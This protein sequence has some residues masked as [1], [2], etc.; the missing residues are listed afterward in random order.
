MTPGRKL[1]N[2]WLVYMCV[3]LTRNVARDDKEMFENSSFLYNLI[4]I[5][6]TLNN[7]NGPKARL[8][9]NISVSGPSYP[10]YIDANHITL[11]ERE[12]IDNRKAQQLSIISRT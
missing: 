3:C 2:I 10:Q 6:Q 11:L 1:I 5:S 8:F 12:V 7:A 9:Y 4:I